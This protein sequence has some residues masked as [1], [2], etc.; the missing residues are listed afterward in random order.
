MIGVCGVLLVTFEQQSEFIA[1]GARL[2][3]NK[4][5]AIR[6]IHFR[7]QYVRSASG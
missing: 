3:G 7:R 2:A 6:V 1:A 4:S 5:P